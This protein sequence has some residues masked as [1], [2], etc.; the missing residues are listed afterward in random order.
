M[1]PTEINE[2]LSAYR[3]SPTMMVAYLRKKVARLARKETFERFPALTRGM[4]KDGLAELTAEGNVDVETEATIRKGEEMELLRAGKSFCVVYLGRKL[5][6]TVE[7]PPVPVSLFYLSSRILQKPVSPTPSPSSDR[8]SPQRISRSS[9]NPTSPLPPLPSLL[10]PRRRPSLS[11]STRRTS[12]PSPPPSRHPPPPNLPR[13]LAQE[14]GRQEHS[15]L[16]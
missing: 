2:E 7:R 11:P 4:A 3:L 6:L 8:T 5:W 10:P 15:S 12:S 13:S 9:S 14:A 16:E 1:T